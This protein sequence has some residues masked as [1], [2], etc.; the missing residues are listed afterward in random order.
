MA[1][2]TKITVWAF[3]LSDG[4]PLAGLTPSWSIFE[5]VADGSTRTPQPTF[6]DTGGGQYTFA[7]GLSADEAFA[8]V[9]DFGATAN[10]RYQPVSARYEDFLT[11]ATSSDVPS[12][13]TVAS[14]VRTELTTELGRIDAAVSSRLAS[15]SYSA[16]PSAATIADAVLDE[17]L[18]GHATAG[19]A[20]AALTTASGYTIP[21]AATI[22]TQVDTTLSSSHGSGTW[23]GAAGSGTEAVTLTFT[24]DGS[25]VQGAKV[26]IYNGSG[27][28]VA[29]GSTNSAG[30][31]TVNLDAGTYTARA[32][33]PGYSW[34]S[35]SVVVT[36]TDTVTPS[37]INGSALTDNLT[38]R[39]GVSGVCSIT[40][41]AIDSLISTITQGENVTISR[42]CYGVTDG[43]TID[44][45]KLYIGDARTNQWRVSG[46]SGISGTVSDTG[47][48][49][50]G[51]FSFSL[52]PAITASA[53]A[54]TSY[55]FKIVVVLAS[56][57]THVPESGTFRVLPG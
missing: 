38:T 17:A 13:A 20:G 25:A 49:G 18:S 57:T 8:G 1:S 52:T 15:A 51:A 23:G 48:D 19:T 55:D 14:Q 2:S 10:P 29:S 21:S 24:A 16:P 45:A 56:G 37:T 44:T 32:F 46:S 30:R 34:S 12:A 3:A 36:A 42:T 33:L 50:T 11:P 22:A 47:A 54:D 6:T 43:T 31:L 35:T 53:R 7:H 40:A 5:N 9:I 39:E 28:S 4:S 41:P 27:T 26:T